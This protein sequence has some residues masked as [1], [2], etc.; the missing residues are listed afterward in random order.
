MISHLKNFFNT[1]IFCDFF[2]LV[3]I[4]TSI[5]ILHIDAPIPL[6]L[7]AFITTIVGFIIYNK[8]SKR[9]QKINLFIII[10][11]ILLIFW[12]IKHDIPIATIL[13]VLTTIVT[14]PMVL[15]M[16]IIQSSY[17]KVKEVVTPKNK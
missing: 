6:F 3:I 17:K 7:L 8:L 2:S 10:I 9:L 11:L 15:I 5:L 12:D 14:L 1:L 13:V 16:M 4:F